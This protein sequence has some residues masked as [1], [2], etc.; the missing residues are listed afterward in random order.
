VRVATPSDPTPLIFE[1][2]NGI[3][4]MNPELRI[5]TGGA[6]AWILASAQADTVDITFAAADIPN[7]AATGPVLGLL[8]TFSPFASF[9]YCQASCDDGG[10]FLLLPGFGHWVARYFPVPGTYEYHS[11]RHNLTGRIIVVDER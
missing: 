8:A 10:N 3:N 2:A 4:V 9:I 1:S 6:V 7:V 11:T 5:G